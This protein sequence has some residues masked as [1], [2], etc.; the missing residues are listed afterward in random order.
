MHVYGTVFTHI[1]QKYIRQF[2]NRVL[3]LLTFIFMPANVLGTVLGNMK[4]IKR[5]RASFLHSG[6]YKQTLV[7]TLKKSLML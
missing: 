3:H 7:S 4:A 2:W 6:N 1:R 5:Y